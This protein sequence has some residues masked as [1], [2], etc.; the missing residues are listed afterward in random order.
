M[1]RRSLLAVAGVLA[2]AGLTTAGSAVASSSST[3]VSVRIEGLK[4]TLLPATTVKVPATGS[5]TKGGTPAGVCPASTAAGALNVATHHNWGGKYSSGL[6]VEVLSVLGE[7]H[8]FTS[9]DYW[10]ILVNNKY[11]ESGACGLKLKPGEHIVFA[12]VP[13]KGPTEYPLIVSAPAHATAGHAFTVKVSWANAKGATKP[14]AGVS[15]TGAGVTGKTGAVTVT[16]SK[17]GKLT[18]TASKTGYIRDEATVSVA[19]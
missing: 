12:A 6:G 4:R 7:S 8:S 14:L 16:A 15:V 11:A 17:A 18:L 13:D 5:I 10:S 19:E 9:S 3:G 2:L 1:Y